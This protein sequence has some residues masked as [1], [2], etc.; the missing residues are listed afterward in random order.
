MYVGGAE[1]SVLHLLYSRF[2]TM[3]L[4]DLGLVQFDEPFER[5]RAHGLLTLN[6]AKMSKSRG[7][8]VNPDDVR[9]RA[10]APTPCA[11]T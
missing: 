5:F 11:C 10:T 3:A 7:N 2:I 1:H 6:G 8:V 4:H 9:R